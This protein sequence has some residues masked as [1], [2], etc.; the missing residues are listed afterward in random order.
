MFI[1]IGSVK[2]DAW[3]HEGVLTIT[4]YQITI[5]LCTNLTIFR[6]WKPPISPRLRRSF[7]DC[8]FICFWWLPTYSTKRPSDCAILRTLY[9][10]RTSLPQLEVPFLMNYKRKTLHALRVNT[11]RAATW[12]SKPS[13]FRFKFKS[14]SL[15][16]SRSRSS[17]DSLSTL[18]DGTSLPSHSSS[19]IHSSRPIRSTAPQTTMVYNRQLTSNSLV[20]IPIIPGVRW[21]MFPDGP[22]C[23]Y[24]IFDLQYCF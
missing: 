11:Q 19:T 21:S 5:V 24:S 8:G 7:D 12:F 2:H 3:K 4:F 23:W 16:S 13:F 15:S 10:F 9:I 18:S 20:T 17:S 14:G 22:Q 6:P 1:D